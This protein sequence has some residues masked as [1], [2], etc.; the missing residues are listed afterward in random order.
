MQ[1]RHPALHEGSDQQHS[2][3]SIPAVLKL[4]ILDKTAESCKVED[5]SGLGSH[6]ASGADSVG[7]ERA[8]QCMSYWSPS[9]VRLSG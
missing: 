9:E 7:K 1:R 4:T 2:P 5:V 6:S 8:L 3:S